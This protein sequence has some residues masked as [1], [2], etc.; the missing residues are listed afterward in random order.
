MG[1][2][3]VPFLD[4]AA[5]HR[6]LAGEIET[7]VID[8]LRSGH[9][10]L[11][12]EVEAFEDEFAAAVGAGHCV[13]VGNGLD[14][15]RLVLEGWGIG[16]GD[17]VIVP[18]HTYI[19]TWFAVSAVGARPVPVDV[20]ETSWLIDPAAV[21]AAITSRTRAVVAVHLYG[22]PAPVERLMEIAARHGLKLLEDAAQAHGARIGGR[23]VG[24]LG[25]AAAWSFYPVKNLG[26]AGDAGAVTTN[27]AAL[28]HRIKL[29]RNQG[30]LTRSVHEIVGSNSRLD[31]IQAVILRVQLRALSRRNERRRAVADRYLRELAGT[32]LG[33]PSIGEGAEPVWHQFVVRHP[34]RDALRVALLG[35]GI[36][37]LIHYETPPHL[38]P[39][40]AHLGFVAG[41][42]PTSERLAREVLS[43]PIDPMLDD[44]S[45]G[46]VVDALGRWATSA[47]GAP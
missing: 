7:A 17:E 26:A 18:V 23:A 45:V 38:Q 2:A 37:T 24:T 15:L 1:A 47:E 6:E 39:A 19:A 32:S 41:S 46:L 20:D 11:G 42:F 40:Y 22:H 4:L 3:R 35:A 36:E 9:Y 30:S 33:L 12:P 10:I 44:A 8:L 27:D 31:P 43:L 5:A 14:A 34:R 25:D 13:G 16:P 29:A 28:A 21:E